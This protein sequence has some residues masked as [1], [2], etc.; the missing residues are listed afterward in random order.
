VGC[1]KNKTTKTKSKDTPSSKLLQ[2]DGVPR[3][4]GSQRLS[5][6]DAQGAK[7]LKVPVARVLKWAEAHC[8]ARWLDSYDRRGQ[9]DGYVRFDC[10]LKQRRGQRVLAITVDIWNLVG[11]AKD[12]SKQVVAQRFE[13]ATTGEGQLLLAQS[14]R[15]WG[16]KTVASLK[17]TGA[18]WQLQQRDRTGPVANQLR[19]RVVTH[20]RSTLR[21]SWLAFGVLLKAGEARVGEC[22]R[23]LEY[24]AA[25]GKD[26]V[27]LRRIVGQGKVALPGG[28]KTVYRVDG[29]G[30]A[31]RVGSE[32]LLD[33]N[34]RDL[35]I[36]M[37]PSTY[38]VGKPRNK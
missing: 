15:Q 9:V 29:L 24:T 31:R 10:G 13:Y 34:G 16:R 6:A 18:A 36:R 5:Q 17:R 8:G 22:Y 27:E 20:V 1:S 38:R 28:T 35:L 25:E 21:N 2:L 3:T 23:V 12:R 37:G 19:Q 4:P 30:L 32:S 14:R 33:A 26:L 7:E 11:A